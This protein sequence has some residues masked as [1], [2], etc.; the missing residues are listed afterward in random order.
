MKKYA[1]LIHHTDYHQFLVDLQDLGVVDVVDKGIEPDEATAAEILRLQQF[2]K[3]IKFLK[4]KEAEA[5]DTT[6]DKSADE[7]LDTILQVQSEYESLKQKMATLDKSY[8]ALHPWGNFSVEDLKKLA[9]NGF[10]IRFYEVTER[11]FQT[12]WEQEFNLEVISRSEGQVYFIIVQR[13]GEHIEIDADEVKA[14]ERPASEVAQ[15]KNQLVSRMEEI[16]LFIHGN[17]RA[18]IPVL[19]TARD[20]RENKISFSRVVRN[21]G[22]EAADRL[23]I[24]EGWVPQSNI[25]KVNAFLGE[26]EV[27]YITA[28]PDKTDKVPIMLKNSNFSKLFEPIGKLYSLPN[29]KELDLTPFFAPF[30]MLFFGFCLGDTGYGLLFLI[31]AT[32]FKK[33]VSTDMRPVLTLL[34]WLGGATVIFGA[35]SGTFFGMNLIEMIDDG[36]LTWLRSMRA[37]M[38]DSEKMFYFA[39]VL[40]AIQIVYGMFIKA[41]NLI[42]QNGIAYALTTIGWIIMILG[43]VAIFALKNEDNAGLMNILMYAVFAVSGV[44]ILFFNNPGKNVFINF[45]GGI[46][47]VYSIATGVLGDLLSYIRLFALGVSSGILGYVFNDLAFQM[48]GST[49]VV[50]QLIFIIILLIGHGLNIFM[51][52]LGAFVHPMRLTFVEFYK[53]AGFAGGGKAYSPFSRK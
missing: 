22:K 51:A 15:E 42:K 16:N 30:F 45:G 12:A 41:A 29:Y 21:T 8:R 25:E 4:T 18:F 35:I 20:L 24:I 6:T 26:K 46:W 49:P 23:M 32:L 19:Q 52:T 47:E 33:K 11:K 37:Y 5:Q 43:L 44:L 39:L 2:D 7:I 40:G 50:S 10:H 17:A 9:D 38:L 36:K 28:D 14:P 3:T 13:E 48:S 34:Q 1:L 31:G 27:F 53:N